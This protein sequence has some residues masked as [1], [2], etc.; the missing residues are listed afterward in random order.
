MIESIRNRKVIVN[1]N[2]NN[3]IYI[4]NIERQ[5]EDIINTYCRENHTYI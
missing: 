2:L 3:N 4:K 5:L 1:Q